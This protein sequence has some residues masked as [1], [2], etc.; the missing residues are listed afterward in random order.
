[1]VKTHHLSFTLILC[2]LLSALPASGRTSLPP[3]GGEVRC[4]IDR[5]ALVA[6]AVFGDIAGDF[7][8]DLSAPASALQDTRA[9]LDGVGAA[10][11]TSNLTLAGQTVKEFP[12]AVADLDARTRGFETVI[13]GIVGA[14]FLAR[15][16]VEIDPSPCRIRLVP[17]TDRRRHGSAR[18]AVTMASG[19]PLVA[20]RIT[21]GARIRSG[22]FALDT[23]EWPTTLFGDRLSRAGPADAAPPPAR[24]RAM[25]LA[26]RLFEQVPAVVAAAPDGG[27]ARGALGLSV[28]SRWSLRLDM[29][30]G[31]LDL[32]PVK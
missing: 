6:P 30:H 23:A 22:L 21:D 18:L 26:G 2:S 14:D 24:L 9:G 8:I 25:T 32:S 28:L 15:F 4:W 1:M 27:V 3:A 7:L 17:Q 13:N 20:A 10:S 19:R 12:M 16:I 29:S 11:A 5:G 31:W